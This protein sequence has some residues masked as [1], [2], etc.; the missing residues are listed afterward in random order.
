[1]AEPVT[2]IN[3]FEV[4][5]GEDEDFLRGW[6]RAADFL[7]QQEGYISTALHQSLSPD[8]TFRFV[9]VARWESPAAFQRAVNSPEFPGSGIRFKAH[10]SLYRIVREHSPA[11]VSQKAD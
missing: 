4:P 7:K 1:M 10:P 2:L 9:N 8:A 6:Q 5:I 11:P 3:A